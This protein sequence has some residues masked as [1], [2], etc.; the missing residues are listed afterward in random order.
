MDPSDTLISS[1]YNFCNLT[2]ID[3]RNLISSL[4]LS[5]NENNTLKWPVHR[6]SHIIP[7]CKELAQI[8]RAH[9]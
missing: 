5:F 1:V 8:G 9:V 2:P 3:Q 6:L 7:L 4:I